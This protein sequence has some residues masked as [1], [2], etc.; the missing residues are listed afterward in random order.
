MTVKELSKKSVTPHV[1]FTSDYKKVMSWLMSK[2]KR[3]AL[4][5]IW[6]L[7]SPV[8]PG[9]GGFCEMLGGGVPLGH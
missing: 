2:A 9:G 1:F 6:Y 5:D 7:S 4:S 3:T 8:R